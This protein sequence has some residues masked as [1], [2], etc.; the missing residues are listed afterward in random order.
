MER[1]N[2]NQI[3]L[4]TVEHTTKLETFKSEELQTDSFKTVIPLT[5]IT[6]SGIDVLADWCVEDLDS[7]FIDWKS[8]NL[9][10]EYKTEH[11]LPRNI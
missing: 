11:Y 7:A 10:L 4:G 5:A 9:I 8:G 2:D 3:S 6:Q 1:T